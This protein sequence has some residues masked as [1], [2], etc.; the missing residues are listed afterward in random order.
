MTVIYTH[1]NVDLDAV[2][3]SCVELYRLGLEPTSDT[4]KFVSADTEM[5]EIPDGGLPVD[6]RARKHGNSDSFVG[7][8]CVDVLPPNIVDEVNEQDAT[9]RSR[10]RVPLA[11]LVASLATYGMTDLEIVQ[12]CYPMVVGWIKLQDEW[13]ETEKYFYT[14]EQVEIGNYIFVITRNSEHRSLSS[15]AKR[16]GINGSIFWSDTGCGISRYPGQNRPDLSTLG[17]DGWF[18]HHIGFLTCWGSRKAPKDTLP[19]QF[20]TVEEFISWLQERPEFEE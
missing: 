8:Y 17:L 13:K 9:G 4:I 18:H 20:R 11:L 1:M 12:Q 2:V 10:N 7:E 16:N 6:I 19:P 15:I 3:G 14:L 5:E